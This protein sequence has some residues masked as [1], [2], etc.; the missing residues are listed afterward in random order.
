MKKFFSI[1]TSYQFEIYDLTALIT[2]LN[3]SLII[4]GFRW[5]P[6]LGLTNCI[7]FLVFAIKNHLHLNTYVTQIALIILNIFFLKG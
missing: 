5:A 4:C 2:I 6:L 1:E 7:I 3:V